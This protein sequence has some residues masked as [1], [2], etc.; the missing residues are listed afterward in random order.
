MKVHATDLSGVRRIEP[1]VFGDDRGWFYETWRA[2]RYAEHGLP[3]SFCQANTSRSARGVLRGIHYQWPE[4]QGK[5]VWVTEGAVL[6]VAVDLRTD[7]PEFGRWVGFELSATNHQQL[8][9]P[10]GFGHGFQV[11]TDHATFSYLCTRPY[12]PEYDASVAW[13]DAAIGIDWPMRPSS[14][15][16]KDAEAPGLDAIDSKELPTCEFC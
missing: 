14:L 12:R 10:E 5:L 4:P 7:S 6:D 2:E 3:T 11:L 16:V 9:I 15:S 1:E 13:N 8:W